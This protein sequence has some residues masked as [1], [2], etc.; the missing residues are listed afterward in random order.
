MAS[1]IW[2]IGV[3]LFFAF[4][5]L[6]FI[7]AIL[8]AVKANKEDEENKKVKTYFYC[9]SVFI[10]F[11][12]FAYLI[13]IDFM[14]FI[15][16]NDAEFIE[17]MTATARN[18]DAMPSFINAV[19][20]LAGITRLNL[21]TTL[22]QL[23]M[24]MIFFAIGFLT[25]GT[26]YMVFNKTHYLL[27]VIAFV[28]AP[29]ILIF[30]YEI[31]HSIYFIMYLA[32]VLWLIVYIIVAK[33]SSDRLKRNAIMLICGVVI[34][35]VGVFLNSETVLGWFFGKQLNVAEE[36]ILVSVL[37]API[38]LIAGLTIAILAMFKKF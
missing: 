34:F 2:T 24:F 10:L 13:R 9:M 23:H 29:L 36:G 21:I 27:T 8:L 4:I 1:D 20:G 31:A 17:E 38:T 15:A 30:P 7:G 5:S 25:L 33:N 3:A 12:A 26:E 32:P 28:T 14:F 16:K 35:I 19:P 18:A 11:L 22:W 6:L 37:A